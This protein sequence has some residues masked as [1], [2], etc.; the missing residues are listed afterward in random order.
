MGSPHKKMKFVGLMLAGAAIFAYVGVEGKPMELSFSAK[1]RIDGKLNKILQILTQEDDVDDDDE[2]DDYDEDDEEE[3]D[4][5]EDDD[6]DDYDSF[7]Q[8]AHGCETV[9]V[10]CLY[11]PPTNCGPH[12][13]CC[14]QGLECR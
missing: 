13:R 5:N 10:N 2:D 8:A 7:D 1:E 3:N 11:P 12:V 14:C 4:E 9:G 6:E